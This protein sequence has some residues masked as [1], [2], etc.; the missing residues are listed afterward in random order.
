MDKEIYIELRSIEEVTHFS[1]IVIQSGI[2]ADVR[3]TSNLHHSVSAD[4]V[5]GLLTLNLNEVLVVTPICD[6]EQ[7]KN[8]R[9]KCKDWLI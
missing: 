1:E 4:S 5:L 8:L 9:N 3:S 7:Y 6:Q 2:K